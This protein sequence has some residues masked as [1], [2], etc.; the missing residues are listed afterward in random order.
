MIVCSTE[1]AGKK[2]EFYLNVYFNQALR[3][4]LLKRVFHPED[5]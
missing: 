1:L 5:K 2:G 4:V 3:D